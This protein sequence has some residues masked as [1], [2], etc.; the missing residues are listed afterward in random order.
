[1]KKIIIL[2]LLIF[3]ILFHLINNYIWLKLDC[4]FIYP[5]EITNTIFHF[6]NQAKFHRALELLLN[7]DALFFEKLKTFILF[8]RPPNI[9]PHFLWPGFV[10]FITSIFTMLFGLSPFVAR[11][12]H[13]LFLA[14][15]IIFSYL[16]GKACENKRA[17][18]MAA[19]LISF[20]PS[21]FG[22]SRLYD[23]DFHLMAMVSVAIYLLIKTQRFTDRKYSVL[24][25][26][27]SGL[28]ILTN[29][30]FL[31]F[32]M[33][34]LFYVF[35][36]AFAD[37]DSS[38]SS[39]PFKKISNII[40]FVFISLGLSSIWWF[41]NSILFNKTLTHLLVGYFPGR[42]DLFGLK[43]DPFSMRSIFFHI[44]YLIDHVSIYF[45]ILFFISLFWVRMG[46]NQYIKIVL[47]WFFVPLFVF[48]AVSAKW[49][50]YCFAFL[51][52]VAILTAVGV[53][54]F[55]KKIKYAAILLLLT[56]SLLQYFEVSYRFSSGL[57]RKM[58]SYNAASWHPTI[59]NAPY[60][61]NNY[62]SI[63]R[64]FAEEIKNSMPESR[65]AEYSELRLG[66]IDSMDAE[67]NDVLIS[68]Y[69]NVYLGN[70]IDIMSLPNGVPNVF[71]PSKVAEKFSREIHDFDFIIVI[72]N[73]ASPHIR[74]DEL[75]IPKDLLSE[76]SYQRIIDGLSGR[77]I[78]INR[79]TLMPDQETIFLLGEYGKE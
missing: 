63:M 67:I 31:V 26:L 43:F 74:F 70:N 73:D 45:F 12:S 53:E 15:I 55:P 66:V 79:K 38:D 11:F 2:I 60:K 61:R 39:N 24:L 54:R 32:I 8:F 25:G 36:S 20:Y 7:S 1:M 27:F 23:L 22:I 37:R 5:D 68:Y 4:L 9:W 35:Y 19:F 64:E 42:Y 41:G 59:F 75:Y 28:G 76:S 33:G 62:E 50:H 58:F 21:V 34:P 44:A 17:G 16:I 78:I 69:M 47:L 65:E 10:Y 71:Y 77:R 57:I 30:R 14:V 56:I 40:I 49:E 3:I 6:E 52:S 51:P 18:I 13:G 48:T 29:G 72:N 46:L